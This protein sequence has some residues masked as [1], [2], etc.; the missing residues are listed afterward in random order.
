MEENNNIN[1]IIY[2]V[3]NTITG[4]C[5]IGATTKSIEER[6][7]DHLQ[8]SGKKVG[9]YFQEAIA[10]YPE[11]S[12]VWQ[13][14]DTAN[15]LNEL[16][17]KEKNYILQYDSN[18]HGFNS[19]NG[20]GFKKNIYQYDSNGNLIG[21]FSSL[22]EINA[23][24]NFNKRRISAACINSTLFGGSF[25]SYKENNTF[26]AAYDS[27]KRTVIQSDL[28]GNFVSR[29]ISVSN[30][31]KC[32]GVSKTCIARCCRGERQNSEGYIWNY[33]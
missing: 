21:T 20:G 27:R 32:T 2:S 22:S 31:S 19:D 24:L 26:N 18:N 28:H 11:T 7:K 5:Y 25:W 16:A 9:S 13:T 8:K 3:K 17:E 14:I 6:K 23:K 12:F 33:E 10:T 30:A 29:Y 15:T 1:G 4:E